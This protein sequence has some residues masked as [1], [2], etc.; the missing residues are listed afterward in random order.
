MTY[1]GHRLAGNRVDDLSTIVG[2][3]RVNSLSN[4]RS[5]IGL[6]RQPIDVSTRSSAMQLVGSGDRELNSAGPPLAED[7]PRSEPIGQPDPRRPTRRAGAD[8]SP[9]C[10]PACSLVKRIGNDCQDH[11]VLADISRVKHDVGSGRD[12]ISSAG[13][14][15]RM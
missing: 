3:E 14:E 2:H 7:A 15:R 1:A 13:C 5:G 4:G 8:P 12:L 6:P 11:R 9:A 10:L